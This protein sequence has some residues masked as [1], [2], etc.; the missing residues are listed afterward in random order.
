[1]HDIHICHP[2]RRTRCMLYAHTCVVVAYTKGGVYALVM[3][4]E[5]C[6]CCTDDGDD[7]ICLETALPPILATVSQ[8]P[9]IHSNRTV[10]PTTLLCFLLAMGVMLWCSNRFTSACSS[11]GGVP[12]HNLV[13][14]C[15]CSNLTISCGR[16]G[17]P[18]RRGR[19]DRTVV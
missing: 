15:G 5:Q 16:A 3:P 17:F 12:V 14:R 6:A 18:L 9:P 4:L 13:M 19:D 8:N 2:A 7:L 1:M 11:R 10:W